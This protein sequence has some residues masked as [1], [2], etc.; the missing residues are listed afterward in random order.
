[1]EMKLR[2]VAPAVESCRVELEGGLAAVASVGAMSVA[3]VDG[4]ATSETILGDD[5][6]EEGGDLY[7][8]W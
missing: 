8:S 4:W 6:E 7:W 1:M 2:Y 5:A 3:G